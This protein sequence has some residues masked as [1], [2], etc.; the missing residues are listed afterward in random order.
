MPTSTKSPEGSWPWVN[1]PPADYIAAW[2]RIVSRF[3]VLGATNAEWVW[4]PNIIS[5][6]ANDFSPW[7]PGDAYVDWTGLDGYNWG[8]VHGKWRSFREVFE[9]SLGVIKRLSPR[10]V[11]IC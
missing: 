6:T 9:Y 5:G 11:I 10:Y 2:K 1:Q 3:R 4:S 7:Y 8:S